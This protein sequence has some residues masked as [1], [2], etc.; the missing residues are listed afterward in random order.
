[1]IDVQTNQTT[2]VIGREGENKATTLEFDYSSW[3]SLYGEGNVILKLQR[4]NDSVPYPI[5]CSTNEGVAIWIID[6]TALAQVGKGKLELD[7]Y[8]GEI[9]KKSKI[10]KV[11]I[12]ESLATEGDPPDPYQSWLDSV[13]EAKD[14]AEQAVVDAQAQVSLAEEQVSLAHAQVE[15]AEEWANKSY[16]YAQES[17]NYEYIFTDTNN[18]GNVQVTKGGNS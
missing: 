5:E 3:V 18:D 12:H 1:M 14:E 13:I 8:V 17:K 9:I 10:F 4:P 7:Y 11:I 16:Q 15:D 2:I 6:S